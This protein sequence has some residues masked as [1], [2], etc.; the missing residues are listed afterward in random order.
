MFLQIYPLKKIS[1]LTLLTKPHGMWDLSSP[2]RIQLEPPDFE[3]QSLNHCTAREAPH[4]C[5]FSGALEGTSGEYMYSIH[6]LY[7]ESYKTSFF[8]NEDIFPEVSPLDLFFHWSKW[9]YL[10]KPKPVTDKGNDVTYTNC[11]LF[12]GGKEESL[13][14]SFS[15]ECEKQE[16]YSKYSASDIACCCCC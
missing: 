1:L 2:Q 7:C 5:L 13:P 14:L 10:L 6:R 8:K 12:F 4:Y 16:C 9:G 15:M 11:S 3:A